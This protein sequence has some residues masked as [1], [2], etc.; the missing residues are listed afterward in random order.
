MAN[1]GG[2]RALAAIG[3]VIGVIGV[4]LAWFDLGYGLE[5]TGW[6]FIDSMIESET[7]DVEGY[8]VYMPAVVMVFSVIGLIGAAAGSKG[9]AV[10]SGILVLAAFVLFAMYSWEGFIT[11]IHMYDYLGIGAYMAAAS[12]FILIVAG[13][14]MSSE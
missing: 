9:A 5:V 12:G 6:D 1:S 10:F 7:L 2:V 3:G 13:A 8:P 11:T 4:F 14:S